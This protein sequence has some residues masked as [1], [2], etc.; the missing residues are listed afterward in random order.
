MGPMTD[1][2]R[3]QIRTHPAAGAELAGQFSMYRAGAD[4]IRHHHERWDGSGYPDG[5]AGEAIPLGARIIAVAD[6]Y[7]AMTSDRPYRDALADEGPA[8]AEPSVER[9]SVRSQGHRGFP[10]AR[11]GG[12]TRRLALRPA[13][14]LAHLTR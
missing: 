8:V 14:A 3:E 1:E 11:A 6:A 12:D 2:E 10:V 13:G 7:D 4:I 5:I 9:L